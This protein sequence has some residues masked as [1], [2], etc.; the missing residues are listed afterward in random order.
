MM[1]GA[2]HILPNTPSWRDTQLKRSIGTTLPL[3][4]WL[5][6]TPEFLVYATDVNIL[7]ENMN[8]MK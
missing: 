4:L 8:S 3:P 7:S 6:G 5:N 1:S 2:V